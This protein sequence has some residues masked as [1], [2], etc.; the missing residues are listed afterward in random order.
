[1]MRLI[2][3][4]SAI[5]LAYLA[6]G[7]S[8]S[9][10]SGNDTIT[11]PSAGGATS[12][13]T[14]ETNSGGNSGSSASEAKSKG[15]TTASQGGA[16]SSVSEGITGGATQNTNASGSSN[17]GGAVG[18]SGGTKSNGGATTSSGST[19]SG[20][21]MTGGGGT[22]SKTGSGTALGG[23]TATAGGKNTSGTSTSGGGSSVPTTLPA[24]EDF[25]DK[26]GSASIDMVYIPGG[27]F[28]LGCE[29]GTCDADTSPVENITVS[30][31]HIM[32][33]EVPKAV[34]TALGLTEGTW[35]DCMAAA[36]E[37]TKQ[38]GHAYRVMTEAE[39]EYAAK[40]YLD[41]L[42]AVNATE[43]WA[44]N[45]WETKYSC[46]P[47]DVDPLGPTPGAHTQKTRRDKA[48]GDKI[49]G[50]LIRSIDGIG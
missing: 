29:S 4:L 32:K 20:G 1:M 10:Q 49:T 11:Q 17:T 40:K 41:K 46:K 13:V 27:T 50:R 9:N 22:T 18:G 48:T 35:Y 34:W 31:Y 2:V 21:A 38:T 7:C 12:K 6:L 28:T 44:F 37:L 14:S 30:D 25:T 33:T 8:S 5:T 15:G 39:F 16:S 45:S 42:S 36:C 23:A 24:H 47:G 3:S 26:V 43:E 19:G